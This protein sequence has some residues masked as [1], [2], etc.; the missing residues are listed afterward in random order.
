[1]NE[2]KVETILANLRSEM[3]ELY[4]ESEHPYGTEEYK[5]CI[6]YYNELVTELGLEH[7]KT[8]ERV[9]PR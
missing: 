3:F 6:D 7:L 5:R 8:D 2:K 4:C 1:M 9:V